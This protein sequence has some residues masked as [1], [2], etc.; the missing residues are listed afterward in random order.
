MQIDFDF[1][2]DICV[3]R[4]KGRFLT[5]AEGTYLQKR[6]N[7]LRETGCRKVVVDFQEIPYLDSTGIGFLVAGYTSFLNRNGWFVLV[8]LGPRLRH[9]L[10][11]TRPITIIPVFDDERTAT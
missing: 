11:L 7:E 6:I 2:G 10:E 4:L 8:N 9:V 5:G 3:L 1:Q